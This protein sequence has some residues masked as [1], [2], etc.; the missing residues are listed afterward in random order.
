MCWYLP[1]LVNF[2]KEVHNFY[3]VLSASCEQYKPNF[4]SL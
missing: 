2:D 3:E 4:L 1:L